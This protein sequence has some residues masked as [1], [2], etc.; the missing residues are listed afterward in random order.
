M[1]R[2]HAFQARRRRAPRTPY[3]S[4][5]G[6]GR[7]RAQIARSMRLGDDGVRAFGPSNLK[8]VGLPAMRVRDMCP[9]P[10]R[11]SPS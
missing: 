2:V 6:P 11:R 8:P 3:S 9:G 5:R 4:F 1:V 7:M 10:G